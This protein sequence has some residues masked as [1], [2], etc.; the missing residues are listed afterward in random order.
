VDVGRDGID[1][2]VVVICVDVDDSVA[3]GGTDSD[4]GG[5]GEDVDGDVCDISVGVM[6][7]MC[8]NVVDE[9][10]WVGGYEWL[11]A[12]H[13]H[14]LLLLLLPVIVSAYV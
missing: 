8:C 10:C 11:V 4:V 7:C 13:G 1:G 2:C 12:L 14:R 9:Y 3:I 6:V 5:D